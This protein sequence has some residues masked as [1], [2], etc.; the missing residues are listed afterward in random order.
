MG[1]FNGLFPVLPGK[2][3]AF[4]SFVKEVDGPRREGFA[5][6]QSRG[7]VTRETW[8]LASTPEGS[9][10]V[11]WFEGNVEKAF[12]DLATDDDEFTVWFRDR[13]LDVTGMDMSVTDGSPPPE[14]VLDWSA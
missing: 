2:E 11:V 7:D 8:T 5:S 14:T 9:V 10:V 12:A 13:I 4:R 6:L 3:D 1:V